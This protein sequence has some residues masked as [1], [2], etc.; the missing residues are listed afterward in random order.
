MINSP[1]ELK[2]A[3]LSHILGPDF[4]SFKSFIEECNQKLLRN[5][6]FIIK[7]I[8]I[9]RE[10]VLPYLLSSGSSIDLMIITNFNVDR[11]SNYLH[12]VDEVINV[13]S[14]HNN[15]LEPISLDGKTYGIPLHVSF[16]VL[17]YDKAL[18][19]A[20]PATWKDV[21]SLGRNFSKKCNPG[22]PT[23]YAIAV[24]S[25]HGRH[26]GIVFESI[27]SSLGGRV[28]Y[29]PGQRLFNDKSCL[30]EALKTYITL[31]N[32]GLIFP[33]SPY[34]EYSSLNQAFDGGLFPMMIQWNIG[35]FHLLKSSNKALGV[36]PIP[37]KSGSEPVC[38]G[39]V[40]A[41]GVSK[42]S[43]KLELAL[44]FLEYTQSSEFCRGF[45]QIGGFPPLQHIN[46]E[47]TPL[48]SELRIFS[49]H[50]RGCFSG[51][52]A[53]E[54]YEMISLYLDG[55]LKGNLTIERA[56]ESLSMIKIPKKYI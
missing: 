21:F 30:E 14:F 19:H 16:P 4:Q 53:N 18:V 11:L 51:N 8:D 17:I 10:S 32:D 38:V 15:V 9:D 46:F 7:V 36:A 31:L 26:S 48:L 6:R 29:S 1:V 24:Y 5:F 50:F 55:F 13:K 12:P 49:N 25:L 23:E 33:D 52:Q 22:S 44:K 41:I 3:Y 27:Y 39:Y 2:L 54:L 43:K 45:A 47:S 20:P 37:S 40:H 56:V 42:N 35:V 34:L 28:N